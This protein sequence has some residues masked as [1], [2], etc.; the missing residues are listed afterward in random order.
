[1]NNN[2]VIWQVEI[3]L[4]YLLAS[5]L[6]VCCRANCCCKIFCMSACCESGLDPV[7]TPPVPMPM[8]PAKLVK[9]ANSDPSVEGGG[10]VTST[11]IPVT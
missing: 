10:Q 1:M 5:S 3:G 7:E 9:V 11:N 4:S 2:K 6:S 8:L